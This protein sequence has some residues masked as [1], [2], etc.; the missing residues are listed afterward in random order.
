MHDSRAVYCLITKIIDHL[1]MTRN[2]NI[3]HAYVISDV[4]TAQ[5]KSK[6]PLMN[7][8]IDDY[9]LPWKGVFMGQD[10]VKNRCNGEAGVLKSKATRSVKNKIAT[11]T[12]AKTFHDSVKSTMEKKSESDDGTYVHERSSPVCQL[13]HR[14][15]STTWQRC[16]DCSRY[17]GIAFNTWRQTRGYKKRLSRFCTECIVQRFVPCLQQHM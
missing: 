10:V 12:N 15:T 1:K 14:F 3:G 6:V 5:C 4:C 7:V 13:R 9:D 11:I 2:I 17:H 16:K 8:G